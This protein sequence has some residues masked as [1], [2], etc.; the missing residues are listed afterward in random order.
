M[1]TLHSQLISK[2]I[3]P[4][5]GANSFCA[6]YKVSKRVDDD[7]SIV[8]GAFNIE[9][10][11][12]KIKSLVGAFGGMGPVTRFTEFDVK[13]EDW[14][15]ETLDKC[16]QN[17]N[18]NYALPSDVP[19]G[20]S[21]YRTAMTGS[22]LTKFYLES[23]GTTD[24]E[25]NNTD[26]DYTF[27]Q[28]YPESIYKVVGKGAHMNSAEKHVTGT[29]KY[30]DDIPYAVNECFMAVVQSQR[31]HAKILKIDYKEAL[32]L[33]GVVGYAD[34][35]DVLGSNDI[36]QM[37]TDEY[38]EKVYFSDMVTS[39]GQTIAAI[40]AKNKRTAQKG[41][42]LNFVPPQTVFSGQSSKSRVRRSTSNTDNI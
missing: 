12:N 11:S 17:L 32:K 20:S 2:L 4:Q 15:E 35:N 6:T 26:E 39:T 29:S 37:W 23:R 8:N 13:S 36:V 42:I 41:S 31:P 22:F 19:G 18:T 1:Q 38:A 40:I 30:L 24:N 25:L 28:E 3:I 5:L 14:N 10:E 27:K 21:A 9:L 7:I 33:D 16:I 34:Q